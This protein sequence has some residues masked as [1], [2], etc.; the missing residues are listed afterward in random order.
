MLIQIKQYFNIISIHCKYHSTKCTIKASSSVRSL[1]T[2]RTNFAHRSSYK[3]LSSTLK[4]KTKANHGTQQDPNA[5]N[6]TH[7]H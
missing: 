7:S 4:N 6:K 2:R 1:V 3:G 5:G